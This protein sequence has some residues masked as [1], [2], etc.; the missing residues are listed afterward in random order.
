MWQA[1]ESSIQ[2]LNKARRL[3]LSVKKPSSKQRKNPKRILFFA[4]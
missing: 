1:F 4:C 2:T 3:N